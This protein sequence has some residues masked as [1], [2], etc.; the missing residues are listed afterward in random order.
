M[1]Q[2]TKKNSKGVQGQVR[3]KWNRYYIGYYENYQQYRIAFGLVKFVLS[4]ENPKEYFGKFM[5]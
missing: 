4:Q 3:F 2:D 1:V 5:K